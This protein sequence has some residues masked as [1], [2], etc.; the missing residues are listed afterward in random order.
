MDANK[1]KE[2]ICIWKR[3][4]DSV[5]KEGKKNKDKKRN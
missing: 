4:M 5:A 3:R 1:I 2:I